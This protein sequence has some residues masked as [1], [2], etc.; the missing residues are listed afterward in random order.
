MLIYLHK[1]FLT[2]GS[3]RQ[4]TSGYYLIRVVVAGI[5]GF[6]LRK[7]PNGLQRFSR[8][9]DKLKCKLTFVRHINRIMLRLISFSV[10]LI[11]LS[12]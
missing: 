4:F 2:Q 6:E 8:G 1:N 9:K 5:L 7:A 10:K 12:K 3:L 11:K